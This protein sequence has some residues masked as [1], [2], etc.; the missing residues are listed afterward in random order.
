MIVAA[1]NVDAEIRRVCRERFGA[2]DVSIARRETRVP[3]HHTSTADEPVWFGTWFWLTIT[4]DGESL[5]LG[6]RRTKRELWHLANALPL[7]ALSGR[8]FGTS[9]DTFLPWSR[10][11]E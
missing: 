11:G 7:E 2:T 5:C 10:R 9:G 6:R 1:D 4:V 3:L 8:N